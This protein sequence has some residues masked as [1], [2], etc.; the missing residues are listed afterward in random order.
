[1]GT[2]LLISDYSARTIQWIL[3][4]QGLDGFQK[5]WVQINILYIYFPFV[6]DNKIEEK[7]ILIAFFLHTIYKCVTLVWVKA[8]DQPT[9]SQ[10]IHVNLVLIPLQEC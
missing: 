7:G 4:W 2:Q 8:G 5:S 6:S 3:T 9:C 1:M 10:K